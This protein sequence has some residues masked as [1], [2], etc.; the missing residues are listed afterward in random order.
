MW[1]VCQGQRALLQQQA[2]PPNSLLMEHPDSLT[3]KTDNITVFPFHDADF[4]RV[5]FTVLKLSKE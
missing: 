2:E 1:G 3:L 5:M 4:L